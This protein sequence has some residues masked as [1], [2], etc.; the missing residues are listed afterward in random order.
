M[1]FEEIPKGEQFEYTNKC[2][3]C[4]K[5]IKLFTQIDNNPE[6]FTYVYIQC[7][8]GEYVRFDLPVN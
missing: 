1:K 6:Y 8:C 2:I 3:N 4:S 5:E 7:N